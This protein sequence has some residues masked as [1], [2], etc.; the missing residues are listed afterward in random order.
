MSDHIEIKIE[1]PRLTPEKFIEAAKSFF[2]LVQGVSK[3]VVNKPI[4]WIAEADKGSAVLRGRAENPGP[5]SSQ[6]IDAICRGIRSLRSGAKA[7]P[8]GFTREEVRACQILAGL[9][10]G[11]AIQSIFIQNGGAPEVI[12]STIVTTAEAILSGEN[13]TAFGSIEGK[14]DSLSDRQGFSCSVYEPYL[15]REIVCYFQKSEVQEEAIKGFRKRVLAG[16]LIRYAKEGHPTSIVVDTIRI[17][18]DESELPTIEEVQ[19]IFK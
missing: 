13:Y 3:N 1:G 11:R 6:A 10:D 18:P 12:S 8:N 17:F 7:I 19:A 9:V 14:I 16:G 2:A 5:E 15:R 4:N